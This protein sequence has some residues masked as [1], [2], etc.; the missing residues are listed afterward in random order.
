[1]SLCLSD[2]E[3]FGDRIE[4]YTDFFRRVYLHYVARP[5]L[6]GVPHHAKAGNINHTLHY[7]FDDAY[8]EKECVVIFDADFM[9]RL[10]NNKCARRNIIYV[11]Y[12]LQ[13]RF[14]NSLRSLSNYFY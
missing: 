7:L 6:P 10:A 5:K 9:P 14:L 3:S 13:A 8:A 4:Q 11:L 2:Q 1:M 12:F